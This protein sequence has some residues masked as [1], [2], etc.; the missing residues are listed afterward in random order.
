MNLK[1]EVEEK[2]LTQKKSPHHQNKDFENLFCSFVFTTPDWK[3]L[4][5]YAIFWNRKGKSMIHSLGRRMK[6]QCP[7][8]EMVLNDLYFHVQVYANDSVSTQKL[9]VFTHDSVPKKEKHKKRELD[10]FFK[11]E[12]EKIDDIIYENNKLII[13][14]RNKVLKTIEV[15]DEGLLAKIFE[16][17]APEYIVDNALSEDSDHPISS[18]AVFNA[19]QEKLDIS[20]VS[21]VALTGSYNDL[22]DTPE[23]FPPEQHTHIANEITDWDDAVENDLE[24]FLDGMIN[25]FDKEIQND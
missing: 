14:S 9:K 5:K 1:F 12:K 11:K 4:E 7:L 15:V 21:R 2:I 6:T 17:S 23:V 13:L 24:N 22:V 25:E 10:Q 19:L 16:G 3:H 20:N 18:K 8:P